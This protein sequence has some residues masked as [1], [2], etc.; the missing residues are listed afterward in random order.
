MSVIL[1]KSDRKKHYSRCARCGK[2]TPIAG[3]RYH[4]L[5]QEKKLHCPKCSAPIELAALEAKRQSLL[6]QIA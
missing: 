1:P 4:W 2:P 3:C 6:R 5:G